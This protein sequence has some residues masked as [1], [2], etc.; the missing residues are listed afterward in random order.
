MRTRLDSVVQV[1]EREEDKVLR[2]VVDAEAKAKVAA[3][4]AEILKKLAQL[5]ARK[6]G[7]AATWEM[8]ETAHVRA[9]ADARRAEKDVERSQQEVA[10]V[11]V[12]YTAAHQR[13]EVVRRV[14][15]TRRDEERRELERVEGKALD[16]VASLLWYRKAG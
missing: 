7:N 3:E 4:K 5:D 6:A 14:A 9:L 12:L 11:R 15:E 13:A 10:K 1:R 2:Q 8:T 16:E